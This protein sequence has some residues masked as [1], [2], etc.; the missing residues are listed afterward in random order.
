MRIL[1]I[2]YRYY[3]DSGP[4]SYLFN[5]KNLLEINGHEIILFSL[6][7]SKNDYSKYKKYFVDPVGDADEFHYSEQNDISIR[8][9]V[10]IVKN[11]FYNSKAYRSL[12]KLI[13]EQKPDIAYVLQFWGKLS[14]SV[15]KSCF[16][17]KIPVVLRLSDYGLICSKNIFYREGAICTK[18]IDNQIHSVLNRC[19]NHS[20]LKSLINY[21]TLRNFYFLKFQNKISSIIVPSIK[22]RRVFKEL[23]N[24]KRVKIHHLPTFVSSIHIMDKAD[25]AQKKKYQFCYSGR[26]A[27]DKGVHTIIDALRLLSYDEKYPKTLIIG[28]INNQYEKNLIKISK[29]N[30]LT[31]VIFTGHIPKNDVVEKLKESLFSIVP[32]IW[33]DN[34]PNSLLEAQSNGLPAI[35]S[36][37]G[38]LPELITDGINGFL[39]KTG[40]AD[41]LSR[42]M[43]NVIN[44]DINKIKTKQTSSLKWAKDYCNEDTHY[45][46]LINLFDNLIIK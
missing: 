28:D 15:L 44:M 8:K 35:V 22:M 30:N 9:K 3:P 29:Q 26:I 4:E 34:M 27:V 25:L 24:Y 36:D 7:Y 11:A 40:N 39:F 17:N 32:S 21:L 5:V 14:A 46:K 12:G 2:H 6:N 1:L 18:C 37:I 42:K 23:N 10:S 20:F 19:V 45:K 13:K 16:D 31:N 38:S 43:L 33:F 41:D